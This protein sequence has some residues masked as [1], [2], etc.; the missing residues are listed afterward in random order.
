VQ[1]W[2]VELVGT[3]ALVS[4]L[5]LP[6]GA[7]AQDTAPGAT[8]DERYSSHMAN[9]VKLFESGDFKA[10]L[11][12]FEAAYAASPRSSPLINQA[13][14]HKKLGRYP[15]AVEKLELALNKHRA[16]LAESDRAAAEAA[17]VEMK[18]LFAFLTFAIVP[19]SATITVDGEEV[20]L[21]VRTSGYAVAP[22]EHVIVITAPR[23]L[24]F[25]RKV[26]L[27]STQREAIAVSLQKERGKLRVVAK[28]PETAIRL[29]GKEIAK[30]SL[31]LELD[32]GN[33]TLEL[34]GE[35]GTGSITIAP[36][37]PVLVDLPAGLSPLPLLPAA[38]EERSVRSGFYGQVNGAVLFPLKDPTRFGRGTTGGGFVG[39]RAG[40]R[41]H[42]YAAFEGL[43]EYGNIAGPPR[44]PAEDPT[45]SLYSFRFAPLLRLMSPGDV[46]HFV[47]TLGGGFAVHLMNYEDP[48][49]AE[50]AQLV[51]KGGAVECGSRGVDIFAM[52]EVGAELDFD[53]VLIGLSFAAVLSGSKG[54]GDENQDD[55]S[56]VAQDYREP[57]GD[58]IVPSIG[59]RVHIGYAFW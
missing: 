13:L 41:V 49:I 19:D 9:G 36:G 30:G 34:V 28:T 18:A 55:T 3:V 11:A 45:Y 38:A 42:D 12:E 47:G 50:Q 37:T 25:E 35:T 22:G 39:G 24:P 44:A 10:A 8:A 4:V 27:A 2:F 14:C 21:A 15:R 16:E 48:P 1:R 17:V 26:T 53:G 23:H 43:F 7:A 5:G 58:E 54:V 51:C 20:P 52:T 33:H 59:P 31:E 57:Y 46:I 32:A 6:S 56:E 29:D 40:Y